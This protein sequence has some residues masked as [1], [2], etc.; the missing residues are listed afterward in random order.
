MSRKNGC[1]QYSLNRL[2]PQRKKFYIETEFWRLRANYYFHTQFPCFP[3]K[4]EDQRFNQDRLIRKYLDLS[5]SRTQ[6]LAL[7]IVQGCGGGAGGGS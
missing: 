5:L 2:L 4:L 3:G 1:F 6:C 7:L